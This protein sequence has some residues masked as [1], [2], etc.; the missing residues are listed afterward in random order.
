MLPLAES[1]E[2]EP[3]TSF[4]GSPVGVRPLRVALEVVGEAALVTLAVVLWFCSVNC[5]GHR[6]AGDRRVVGERLG[7]A[8]AGDLEIVRRARA[9][10]ASPPEV[11]VTSLVV[12]V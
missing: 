3:Q 11:A 4:I 9:L 8:E 10:T 6:A 2:P 12:L 1:C 5:E 7:E